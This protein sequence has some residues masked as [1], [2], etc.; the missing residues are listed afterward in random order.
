MR[1]PA[2]RAQVDAELQRVV[3]LRHPE[4]HSMLGVHPDGDAV[5]VRA[6]R[7]EAVAIHVLPE[8][9]GKVPMQHRTGGVFEA[10]INGRTE[11]FGY[12]LEVEYPGKKVFTLRDPYSFL[13]TIGE[14]DLYFAGEG[15]HERLWERMGAHLIHHNGVKGTSFAVWAPT[16]R[17]V[18]VVGDFNGWD[19]RLHA[20]RRMGSSGIWELFVPEVGEGTRYKFEIRPGHGGGA[21]LKADPFAFRTETPPA[22]ASV[23]HDLQRYA[24]GDSAWLE[25]REKHVDAAQHP[26]S[27]YEVHL[28]SWRRVVEDGDRPMTYRELAPELSRYAKELGFTHVELLPVSEHPYGGSW[29]YQVGGYYAPTSRFGHPDDFRYLVDYLHQEGI[30]VIVDWV[31]GHFP[32]DSHALGQ[33][34]GTSLYE[35]SD[36]RQGSQPDWG[37]LVFNFGRNEVRNFLIANALFWLE[38]YHIDGLR[39]DAV[40]SMLYLDYS[41]KHGEWVPNRWGGRE[42]EEAIQFLRELNDTIRRKHPGVVVIAEESTAWPK[43]SQPVSEGGLG[44]HFKWNMG[45]MH[46]TLSYFSKDAVYRQFHHNQ[47]TFGLLYAFSEHFML[48]LSHDEVVHGK[49]SLYGRMPGDAWQKRANLRALFAWMWAHPGKKL[50]FMGGE[51]GQPAEWNHD[52]SLDW[53]LLNDPGHKG[54]QKLVGDLNRVYRDLPALYDSD[55]E[56]VGFQWLQPDASAANVLAFVRRSRTPGRHVVCVANM[57]PVPREDYRVGFP[58]HGRYV[59]LVNTD[60]GEYGGSGLGNRGQVHTEPTGWDGQPASAALTLPPLSVVWFTPG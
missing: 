32:R 38:E 19:G 54:I 55:S 17:G 4:P 3:E 34:D 46:D 58:L 37:T 52:K 40:A 51:F 22:T 15:R 35:H 2:D 21:L 49:G 16:A 23:V 12:L 27:V 33:F 9:G 39:V 31:P 60:A 20:M 13:P 36:P 28:G 57:S 10:R 14:M 30:G 48:P 8:F 18:S 26:W 6:Y 42:N 53:H 50:L 7:P 44:F 43:V 56:P 45:W 24:W 29:G 1:K 41:R 47:L 5:V 11:P 59:E 25:T